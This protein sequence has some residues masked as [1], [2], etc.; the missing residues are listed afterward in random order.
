MG[1]HHGKQHLRALLPAPRCG[2]SRLTSSE[3]RTPVPTGAEAI[4]PPTPQGLS[5]PEFLKTTP[6]VHEGLGGLQGWGLRALA[7]NNLRSRHPSLRA[8]A[9]KPPLFMAAQ[10]ASPQ[11]CRGSAG[12]DQWLPGDLGFL[13]DRRNGFVLC[14]GAVGPHDTCA[15][16]L[17]AHS[18]SLS[19]KRS[20]S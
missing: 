14:V 2:G 11:R 17:R 15:C 9:R 18:G 4:F 1:V 20:L 16:C 6:F 10:N 7:R 3:C 13:C 8:L 12:R 5:S 19:Q